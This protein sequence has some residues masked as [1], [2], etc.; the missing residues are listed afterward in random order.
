MLR[1][2]S[3]QL[4]LALINCKQPDSRHNLP[5]QFAV[6]VKKSVPGYLASTESKLSRNAATQKQL[7]KGRY[8]HGGKKGVRFTKMKKRISPLI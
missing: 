7:P 8:A 4:R 3:Q 2:D 5:D 6:P 1:L